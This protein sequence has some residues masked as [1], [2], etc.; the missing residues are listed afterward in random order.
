MVPRNPRFGRPLAN[1]IGGLVLI[2]VG[3]WMA[4]ISDP[5]RFG[6]EPAADREIVLLAGGGLLC[7]AL[8]ILF[9]LAAIRQT[10]RNLSPGRIHRTNVGVGG[11]MALQMIG[12]FLAGATDEQSLMGGLLVVMSIPLLVWGCFSFAAGKGYPALLGLFGLLGIVGLLVLLI[13][14]PRAAGGVA[15]SSAEADTPD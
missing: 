2:A 1:A 4:A 6:L 9:W 11:G 10:T 15:P 3:L 13:L 12:F 8:G 5:K 7:T 14:P